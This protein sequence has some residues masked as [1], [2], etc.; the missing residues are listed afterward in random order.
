ME[1]RKRSNSDILNSN[2]NGHFVYEGLGRRG[3]IEHRVSKLDTLAGIAIKY[4]VDVISI[5]LPLL[6]V[7]HSSSYTKFV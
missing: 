1:K 6:P 4:G 2:S 5:S 3:V 7:S